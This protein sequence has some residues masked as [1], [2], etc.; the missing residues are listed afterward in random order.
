M[1]YQQFL[2]T[3]KALVVVAIASVLLACGGGSGASGEGGEG[4]AQTAQ[5]DSGISLNGRAVKGVIKSGIV[6]AYI[7]ENNAGRWVANTTPVTASVRT[8]SQGYYSLAVP[9]RYSGS[10]I[11]IEITADDNTR[12]TCEVADGCG[13]SSAVAFG[14]SFGLTDS[15][16]LSS[17]S[18]PLTAEAD[19]VVHVTPYTH[20]VRV[21]S[22]SSSIG[23]AAEVVAQSVADVEAMLGFG[24]ESL[25]AEPIDLTNQ[26]ELVNATMDQLEIALVSAAIQ[27]AEDSV[28]FDNVDDVLASITLRLSQHESLVLVDNGLEPA[29]ALD[30]LM[31]EA[32]QE[33]A[34]LSSV[35]TVISPD[36]VEALQ[37]GFA[38]A[39]QQAL[40]QGSSV[41]PVQIIG[42]PVN[43]SIES[44]ARFELS[45]GAI[46]GGTIAFQWFK[47]GQVL[48][49]EKNS[50]LTV[51]SASVTNSGQYSVMVSNDVGSVMSSSATVS[52]A[53]P[54][55]VLHDLALSW[56][57]PLERED[58]SSLALYEINGYAI[59]Y[60]Q[61]A[62][63]LDNTV[64]VVGGQQTAHTLN[65]LAAGTYYFAIATIDSDGVQGR[66]SD[67][68]QVLVN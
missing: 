28:Q 10:Q 12:M 43:V 20:M 4:T 13:D 68:I 37:S 14:D 22:E 6:N 2:A 49:G 23:M 55:V 26:Q 25:N 45:V 5:F 19:N 17:V 59:A 38:T 11:L 53:A 21:K 62:S 52:V 36:D 39:Q 56:D 41:T 54:V 60:G 46:G 30:D 47:D 3:V 8:D 66:Y 35:V 29:V 1:V 34:S 58:G 57:I 65:D 9:S 44:G 24:N 15:F 7:V 48:A 61:S 42:Q 18:K 50:V 16:A 64:S 67:A 51:D 27:K 31:Y 32:Q 33:L 40:E 63:Q